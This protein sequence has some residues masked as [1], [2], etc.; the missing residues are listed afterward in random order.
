[1]DQRTRSMRSTLL[2]AC[3]RPLQLLA[4]EPMCLNLCSFSAILLGILY[5]FFGAIPLVFETTYG[6]EQYQTGLA[7]LGLLV[8]ML[9]GVSTDPLWQRNYRRLVRKNGV[10][11]A[12]EGEPEWRLPPAIAGAPMV[13]AGLFIFAWTLYR[14]VHW[15]G[16]IIGSGVY[17]FGMVLVFSGIFTFLVDAYPLYA[18]SA[19]S[20]NSFLRS[21]SAAA[22]PLF[23]IQ[24]YNRLNFHWAS[25]LL[26]FITLAM[27]PF[28][29]IFFRYGRRIRARSRFASAAG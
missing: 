9:I 3:T 27:L 2:R 22:F 13:T 23:G 10:A 6:F 11:T 28:P 26:A 15:I 25:S 18:A 17:G 7:F 21:S 1:M 14:H 19:L 24:M 12:N 20:A 16:P 8:G 5:L 4:L 29:Y